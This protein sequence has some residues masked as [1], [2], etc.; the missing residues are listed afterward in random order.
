LSGVNLKVTTTK[1][2]SDAE[3]TD[4]QLTVDNVE[5]PAAL[6]TLHQPEKRTNALFVFLVLWNPFL[7]RDKSFDALI[8]NSQ[9][10]VMLPPSMSVQYKQLYG[11]LIRHPTTM[12][13]KHGV[14]MSGVPMPPLRSSFRRPV[15]E[16]VHLAMI[17][18]GETTRQ[19]NFWN[20]AATD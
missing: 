18:R 11:K 6:I 1:V 16:T 20:L 5:M 8:R 9:M 19:M 15:I 17:F 4:C 14:M 7:S 3:K 12:T 2:A 13:K 10:R